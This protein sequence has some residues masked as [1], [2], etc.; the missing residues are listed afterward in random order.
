MFLN[1]INCN[2]S[3]ILN[4]KFF[5]IVVNNL[6]FFVNFCDIANYAKYYRKS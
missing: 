4:N 2:E 6:K 1:V 5:K 3:H